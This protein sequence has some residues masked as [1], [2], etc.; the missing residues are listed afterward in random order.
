MLI[1]AAIAQNDIVN[2]V[3]S[4]L[5]DELVDHGGGFPP[6]DSSFFGSHLFWLALSFACFYFLMARLIIP[7]ISNLLEI[8]RDRIASD[9]EQAA[10]AKQEA[11]RAMLLYEQQL[12]KAKEKAQAL[13][14]E[15][16]DKAQALSR[17]EQAK[18]EA[19][20]SKRLDAA[21]EHITTLKMQ[22]ME[23]V[24]K[25]AGEVADSIM[26]AL[27]ERKSDKAALEQ[28]VKLVTQN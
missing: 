19:D 26:F 28:A 11:D 10:L 7:R 3:P 15:A 16:L 23:H 18:V 9:L 22:A 8:R 6:F 21:E 27:T 5:G 17:A 4:G 13:A 12:T 14:R 20:M 24:E 2:S 25:I 1:S